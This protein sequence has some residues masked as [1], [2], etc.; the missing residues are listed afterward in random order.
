MLSCSTDLNH[1]EGLRRSADTADQDHH[2]QL[3]DP[4][5]QKHI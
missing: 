5:A 4:A 2:L 3:V 1:Y